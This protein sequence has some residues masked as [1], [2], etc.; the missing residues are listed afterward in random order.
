MKVKIILLVVICAVVTLSFTAIN[1]AKSTTASTM[2]EQKSAE[3]IGGFTAED[4]L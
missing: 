2:K 1:S 4:K 3:P